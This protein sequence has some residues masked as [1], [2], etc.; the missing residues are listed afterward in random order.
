LLHGLS[1]GGEGPEAPGDDV[2]VLAEPTIDPTVF[3]QLRLLGADREADFVAELV[4]DFIDG[5]NQ[6]LVALGEAMDGC[7]RAAM[8]RALHLIRGSSAQLGGQ[9]LAAT[10]LR[11]ERRAS[12]ES[13]TVGRVD[14]VEIDRA[15]AELCD[16]LSIEVGRP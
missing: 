15:Y 10:C 5:S 6:A 9:Q 3:G 7:D 4:D 14:L 13:T 12:D 16:A 2:P 1:P 11:L 8:G